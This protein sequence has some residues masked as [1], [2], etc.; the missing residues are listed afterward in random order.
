MTTDDSGSEAAMPAAQ[1][2]AIGARICTARA[3]RTIG[4]NFRSRRRI[5]QS[6]YFDLAT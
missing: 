2:A 5:N 1:Q 4:S 6:T 3:S